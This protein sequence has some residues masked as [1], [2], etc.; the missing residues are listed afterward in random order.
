[1]LGMT[2]EGET[3]SV[4]ERPGN[5]RGR[6]R[7]HD[8][9]EA[10]LPEAEVLV[11]TSI[12]SPGGGRCRPSSV[13]AASIGIG[14][15][16]IWGFTMCGIV[17]YAGKDEA[18]PILMDGLR[19]LEYRGYDLAGVALITPDGGLDIRRAAGK[20]AKLASELEPNTPRGIVGVGHT[21]WATHGRPSTENAHP[22]TDCAGRVSVV[23]NGII[24][25]YTTLRRA[26]IERGHSFHSETDTEVLAHLI[27]DEMSQ[28]EKL[29]ENGSPSRLLSAVRRALAKVRGA[30][31]IGVLSLDEPGTI[32]G[33]RQN[34]PL[35]VGLGEDENFLASDIPAL[36]H[37]TRRIIRLAEGEL[38]LVTREAVSVWDPAGERV[39]SKIAY[40]D[41]DQTAAEKSGYPHFVL[42][43]IYEQPEA[44]RNALSGRV[45]RADGLLPELSGV[46]MTGVDRVIMTACGTS[47]Y[48]C[49]I[50]KYAW[51][52][53][54][55]LPVDVAIGSEFRY[56]EPVIDRNTLFIAVSQSGETADTLAAF[57]QAQDGGA[58]TV[59]VAN[60]VGSAITSGADAVLYLQVGPEIGVVATKTFTGQLAVLMLAGIHVA[61][62]LGRMGEAEARRRMDELASVPE[63]VERALGTAD[64]SARIADSV[65][66][67]DHLL[68]LGRGFGYPTA[69]EGALKLKEISYI[70][71]EGYP[72]GELK[73]GPIALLDSS[74]PVLAV[75]TEAR[76]YEK[77][78]SNI[79]EVKARG[80][81]VIAI[82][83]EGDEE[84]GSHVDEVIYVPRVPEWISPFVNVVP[85]QLFSYYAAVSRG[86]DVDQP[87]N[88]A[89]SVTVE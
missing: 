83:S 50:A 71:A 46:D 80:A 35:I 9:E 45:S 43:E 11:G 32:V 75:A 67:V 39:D 74:M 61:R 88:L 21:R 19:R 15:E 5:G 76:T 55:R 14:F 26:L 56:S 48:A 6:L 25:N 57:R 30:Y 31:A 18:V 12:A 78:V 69:M 29:G 73:H 68:F 20:L 40:I 82:A 41:W 85:M 77:M 3:D 64:E 24:E 60:V 86:C 8:G 66:N 51:E 42:K 1:M 17:G 89:K 81:R 23:H 58:R 62:A 34:A 36:L 28:L 84:I 72:A 22:H 33:A 27:E 54:T 7:G 79:Q 70:H 44:I 63:A 38:A 10:R 65:S 87:R 16:S 49:M 13:R 59:A 53:W 52:Q 47:Y 4:W 37:R 2:R